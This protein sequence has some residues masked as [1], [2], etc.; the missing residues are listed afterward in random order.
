MTEPP[1]RGGGLRATLLTTGLTAMAGAGSSIILARTLSPADRGELATVLLW[2]FV[3]GVLGDFGLSFAFSYSVARDKALLSG[4]WTLG[5]VVSLGWGSLLAVV[6]GLVLDRTLVLSSAAR[7]VMFLTLATVPLALATAYQSFLLLGLGALR[8]YNIVRACSVAL[9]V[10]G[11]AG[12]ALLG[13]GAVPEY[14]IAWALAQALTFGIVTVWLAAL[15][16]PRWEWR[17]SL[18]RPVAVYGAKTYA[19]SLTAQMTLRLDQVLM[20]ALGVSAVLGVYVVAVSVASLTAPLFTALAIVVMHRAQGT[21]PREGGRQ[22]LEY[23]QL[24]FVLGVP[25]CLLLCAATPWVVPAVFGNA[26]RGA[27]LPAAILLLASLFQGAN[28]VLGN[29]LRA[30]GL[31]GRPALA[32]ASGFILTLGLLAVLLPRFGAVGAAVGSLVSYASV[33]AIQMAFLHRSSGFSVREALAV[34]RQR[35]GVHVR[36]LLLG[37]SR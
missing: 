30:V 35:L 34:D 10:A 20:T 36:T 13:R 28:A 33:T 9:Y 7:S 2:P 1:V 23:V 25:S 14:A 32:E 15:H 4:L 22:V 31:P 27:V 19:S 11:V 16:R 21:E 17:P 37:G 12:L 18:L 5:W 6:S 8:A 24:A 29:G 3:I 26:Y